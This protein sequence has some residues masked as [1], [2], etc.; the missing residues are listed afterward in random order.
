MAALESLCHTEE[1]KRE[2]VF[3]SKHCLLGLTKY[4]AYP[5]LAAETESHLFYIEGKIYAKDKDTAVGELSV[6]TEALFKRT[7]AKEPMREWLL[8]TDGDFV[9]VII[10]KKSRQVVIFNDALGRLPLYYHH[11]HG[12]LLVSREMRFLA[13]LIDKKT[14][15]KTDEKIFDRMAIA[16][17]LLFGYLLGERSLLAGCR[18]LPPAGLIH[19][20]GSEITVDTVYR[21]NFDSRENAKFGVRENAAKLEELFLEACKSRIGPADKPVVSMSGGLDARSVAAG[22]SKA[23]IS[24]SGVSFL[25]AGNEAARDVAVARQ[26]AELLNIDFKLFRLDPPQPKDALML[27]KMKNGLNYLG[28]SFILPF[29]NQIKQTH[30][31]NV[32]YLTGDGGDFSLRDALPSTKISCLDDLADFI[33]SKERV[34]SPA[35]VESLTGIS[36]DEIRE[37]VK[38]RLAAYPEQ[39]LL[40]KYTRFRFERC[41]AFTFEGEDRNRFYFWSAAPF[42]SVK[43]FRYAL[44]CPEKMKG[45]YKLYREFLLKLSAEVAAIENANWGWPITSSKTK[46]LFFGRDY[47]YP[48]LPAS[49]RNFI[50]KARR[51]SGNG[52]DKK[53][54][55]IIHEQVNACEAISKYLSIRENDLADSGTDEYYVLLTLTSLISMVNG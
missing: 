42:F 49:L 9:I 41:Q 15:K 22:L 3:H 5:F 25:D 55:H 43:F 8:N 40:N 48:N 51:T 18:R 26:I 17:Y 14:D 35:K 13:K 54:M 45:G 36:R 6:L 32:T 21:H 27:L 28:M 20:D 24:F 23:G 7:A 47:I 30:G 4:E 34:F 31:D 37:T 38:A 44:N 19:I 10:Q 50:A 53:D 39:G 12:K 52:A 11:A 29:F 16:N 33:I 1:Y 46:L 2:I